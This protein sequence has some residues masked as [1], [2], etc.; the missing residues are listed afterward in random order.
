[1]RRLIAVMAAA[2][3]A[4]ALTGCGGGSDEPVKVTGMS[5][6]S[7][8]GEGELRP[9]GEAFSDGPCAGQQDWAGANERVTW[10]YGED[11]SSSW[12]S[13]ERVAGDMEFSMDA[14]YRDEGSDICVIYL[15]GTVIITNDNGSWEGT[16]EGTSTYG[17]GAGDEENMYDLEF[18]MQGNG[19]YDGL[20]YAYNVRG[21]AHPWPLT[22]TISKA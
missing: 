18:T 4:L 21:K 1:M 8:S 10:T 20:A 6:E 2:A 3:L 14:D 15:G 19:D 22:G 13:D 5:G 16:W 9:V 7:E 17:P 11:S 12:V